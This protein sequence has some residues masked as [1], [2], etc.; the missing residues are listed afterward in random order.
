MHLQAAGVVEGHVL[1][2]SAVAVAK[3]DIWGERRRR[4][5]SKGRAGGGVGVWWAARTP[6]RSAAA[7]D[8]GRG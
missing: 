1:D 8:G 5:S 3:G 6:V 7:A 2:T 4:S